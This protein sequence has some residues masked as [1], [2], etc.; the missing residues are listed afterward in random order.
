MRL[1]DQSGRQVGDRHKSSPRDGSH[2]AVG[3]G[4]SKERRLREGVDS[5]STAF[6]S[7]APGSGPGLIAVKACTGN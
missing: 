7:E 3:T 5:A 6:G 2:G 1:T 4:G